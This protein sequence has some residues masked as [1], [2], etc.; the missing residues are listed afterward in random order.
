MNSNC[1]LCKNHMS[2]E[3]D[4]YIV[5]EKSE[6][7]NIS[8][9]DIMK[10]MPSDDNMT[11]KLNKFQN[12]ERLINCRKS[13]S[14]FLIFSDFELSFHHMYEHLD[15]SGLRYAHIKGNS[16]NNNIEKYRGDELDALLVNSKN[17]G[18]GLNLENTTDLIL[19]HKFE[20]QLEKQ[21][22]GRAQRP[23]RK[24]PLRIWYFVNDNES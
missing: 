13:S 18:S 1:P 12:L 11:K 16:V 9:L 2:I 19:F 15:N 10:T 24:T 5:H 14:K 4:F 17:Y 21:V 8:L 22:I 20:G 7:S 6:H 23:G 3:E